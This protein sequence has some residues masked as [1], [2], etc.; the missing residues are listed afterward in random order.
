MY[1]TIDG[2]GRIASTWENPEY[3]V[4]DFEFDFPVDFDF[5]CQHNWRL[6][7]GDLVYDPLPEPEPD[8]SPMQILGAQ[9]NELLLAVA[10]MIGG[11]L[12]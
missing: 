12:E 9:V 10:D 7:D 11:A 2:D 4:G 1:V 5:S 6:E 3:G 8:P